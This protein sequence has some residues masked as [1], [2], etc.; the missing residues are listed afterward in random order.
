MT[1]APIE[2]T[3]ARVDMEWDEA[4]SA[5]QGHTLDSAVREGPLRGGNTEGGASPVGVLGGTFQEW[6]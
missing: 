6:V 2:V 4:E 1:K 3:S 5:G